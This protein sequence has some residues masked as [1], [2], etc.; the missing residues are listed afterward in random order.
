MDYYN[1][2]GISRTASPEEIKKAYKKKVMQ[3]HPDRGGDKET[4]QKVSEAYEIL[5]N[6]DK[7]SAYDN[8]QP[9]FNFNTRNTSNPFD[10]FSQFGFG[11]HPHT[12]RQNKDIVLKCTID[13]EDVMIGKNVVMQYKL[14]SKEVE[15]VNLEIPKGARHGDRVNYQGLGDNADLRLPRGNLQVIVEVKRNSIWQRD[16]DNLICKKTINVFDLLLGC[17]I[18]IKTIDNK[19]VNLNIPAGTK[20]GQTFSIPGYGLPNI[21]TGRKGNIFVKI[22]TEIPKIQD[23][24]IAQEIKTLRD[25]IYTKD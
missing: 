8:P 12:V 14:S 2:L 20:P 23:Y 6:S 7:R 21:N 18:M 11:R 22:E 5:S 19:R 10:M 9:D 25:K 3:H 4:F 15:T 17:A 13:L 24:G 16:N 1:I